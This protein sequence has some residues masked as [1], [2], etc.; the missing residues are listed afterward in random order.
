MTKRDRCALE[1]QYIQIAETYERVG[2]GRVVGLRR[3]R[4][5]AEGQRDGYRGGY[6][7]SWVGH[8]ERDQH[9]QLRVRTNFR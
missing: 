3:A 8:G 6:C 4:A 9:F 5:E 1:S 2:R 7:E